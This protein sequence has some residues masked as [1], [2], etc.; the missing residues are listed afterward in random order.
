MSRGDTPIESAPQAVADPSGNASGRSSSAGPVSVVPNYAFVD[1]LRGV[2]ALLV[3]L[4]HQQIHV[5]MDYPA[6]PIPPGSLTWWVFL[7]FFDLGKY[8][9]VVFFMVS[10]FLIPAT[11]RRPGTNLGQF[12]RH[13]F[14]RL[15][16]AYWLSIVFRLIALGALGTL[17]TVNWTD[18]A[19]NLTMLQKFVGKP[20]FIGVFWTLQ[21][22]LTFYAICALLFRFGR[23]E[24]RVEA[25][26]LSLG[27]AL[28]CALARWQTGKPLPVALFLALTVMFAGDS[29]RCYGEGRADRREVR[30]VMW[31]ALLGVVPVAWM[32]Y[33]EDAQRY[34]VTYWAAVATFVLCWRN[35]SWFSVDRLSKRV[36][37]FLG[38]ISYGMYVLGSTILL[39][40]GHPLFASTRN[41]WLTA[42]A[43]VPL[44]VLVSWF[45]YRF[46]ESPAI[47]FGRRRPVAGA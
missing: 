43:V 3:V 16:P 30:R 6:K 32:G 41:P 31:T 1:V 39:W 47:A 44:C 15:Y 7:G 13:R 4:F 46:V 28:L 14:F 10:G 27:C 33:G 12:V 25:Q 40:V 17:S 36:F 20:D 38:E 29:L 2:A 8:A 24:R 21:I 23:L 35:A 11:L 5:F 26:L 9:V 19:V 42:A 22:E 37:G 34:V 45:S 18:V